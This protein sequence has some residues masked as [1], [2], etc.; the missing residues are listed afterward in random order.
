MRTLLILAISALT[1]S[2][3]VSNDQQA[4][5]WDD[6]KYNSPTT[7]VGATDATMLGVQ[8]LGNR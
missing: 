3:C 6:L 1:L 8:S 2:A 5:N 4:R 7:M